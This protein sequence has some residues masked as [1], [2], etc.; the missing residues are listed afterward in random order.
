MKIPYLERLKKG[1][2]LFDSAVGTAIY[3]RGV[4][5]N[6]CYEEINITNPEIVLDIHRANLEAGAQALTTNTFAGSPVK[7][8]AHYLDGKMEE[9]NQ[10]G[11]RLA[12]Q[13]AIE[14]GLPETYVAASIGPLGERLIPLGK[15]SPEEA[16][17]YFLA[18]A[19]ALIE[20]GPDLI[21]LETFRSVTECL[22]AA[23]AVR[24]VSASLPLQAHFSLSPPSGI[25]SGSA[26]DEYEASFLNKALD[27]ALRLDKS[28]LVDVVGCNCGVGPAD[29]L[30]I[31]S[32]VRPWVTKPF[33]VEPNAGFPKEVDGR[34]IYMVDPSYFSE[35]ALRFL[36]GGAN[37]IGGCCG[38]GAEHIRTMAKAV[39]NLDAGRKTSELKPLKP[40]VR[41]KQ[42]PAPEECSALGRA[43][44]R[45]E[46]ITI[47]ELVPPS[48]WD[49][50]PTLKRAQSLK[51][52]GVSFINLPDGP[53]ASSRI[54]GL[55]TAMEIER[56]TGTETLL[57]ICG[58]DRNL[59]ALQGDLL[60]AQAGGL[61]NLLFI[62]GDPP[63][64]GGYPDA[65]GVFDLDSVGLLSLAGRLNRGLD[66][67]G[68]LLPAQ[69]GFVFG[70]GIDPSSTTPEQE[71]ERAFKKAQAGAQF[72]I[73][74]PVF[75]AEA[76]LLFLEKISPAK[77]P[78]IVG[79]WPL[80]SYKNAVFLNNEV[81]GVRIPEE[82]MKRME[83]QTDKEAARREGVRLARQIVE[84]IRRHASPAGIQISPPFG[85]V[86]TALDIVAEE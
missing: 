30:E 50:G 60:G 69:T 53:R 75:D 17:N 31:L 57:H 1:V 79:V 74:Q 71:I 7:L 28:P 72:F 52:G 63:K 13:A 45:G 49:L 43:L 12:R 64:L 68:S 65:T 86:Q 58:R 27:K 84:Q 78:V 59:L 47:V 29:M 44:A 39:L 16:R 41:E 19:E 38:T 46:W 55:V 51:E 83:A 80:A 2:L 73:S 62:T 23:E 85:N 32:A 15:L 81:P 76:L 48:G 24:E 5:V 77:V 34:Q 67:G 54:S 36:N 14:A 8:A 10:A 22:L 56:Q 4:F 66:S 42:P 37:I 26:L 21:L 70:A 18:Q 11:V 33:A 61:R 9:I 20:A 40:E 3:A 6:R 25:T 35:Y 82:I